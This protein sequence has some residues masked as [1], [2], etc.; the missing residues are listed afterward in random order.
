MKSAFHVYIGTVKFSNLFKES[1]CSAVV[2]F[3]S[4]RSEGYGV[5]PRRGTPFSIFMFNLTYVIL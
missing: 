2:T 4:F 3:P 1:P 5:Q